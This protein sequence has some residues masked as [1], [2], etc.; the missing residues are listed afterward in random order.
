[1]GLPTKLKILHVVRQYTPS[2]GGLEAY[3]AQLADR[4]KRH[5]YVEILTLN[6]VFDVDE[7][8]RAVEVIDGVMVTRVPFVG[9]RK[10]FFPMV[11]IDFFKQFDII[12]FHATDQLLDVGAFFARR[13]GIPY[14]VVSHGLFFHTTNYMQAKQ[15]YLKNVTRRALVNADAVFAVSGNDQRVMGEVGVESVLLRNPIEPLPEVECGSDLIYIGR[16]SPNKRV[17]RLIAFFARLREKF[18]P[19]ETVKLHIVGSDTEGLGDKL[20]TQAQ[21]LG[22]AENVRLHGYISRDALIELLPQCGFKVS[23]SEYEGFGLSVVEAMSA[24]MIPFLQR[25][26]AFEETYERSGLGALASFEDLDGA[27]DAFLSMA[28]DVTP[29]HRR[30]A[31]D[32][33]LSHSWEN[34]ER[35]IQG[36]YEIALASK[37]AA[38]KVEG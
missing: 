9:H 2:V 29:E 5:S 24:G 34:V 38:M 35:T 3:V 19:A 12:H 23:A 17:D 7:R 11:E 27:V 21:E 28:A 25:N 18:P 32:F 22:V 14:F 8:L 4:Q 10:M 36:H 26:A 30:K 31:R 1:M 13:L 16:L 6:R 33:G 37:G 15:F 20:L